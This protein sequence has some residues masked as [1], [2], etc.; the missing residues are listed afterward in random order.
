MSVENKITINNLV[1][2]LLFLVFGI[3]LLTSTDDLIGLVSKFIG[4]VLIITGIVKSIV[5]IYMKGKIGDYKL[6]ELI[7][8][9]LIIFCGVLLILYSS[10]LSFAIRI[11]FGIWTLLA[12]I[13]RMILSISV[14]NIDKT[15][16]KTYLVTSIIMIVIGLL[17]ISGLFDRLIGLFII[18]YS[19]LEIIDYVY[20]KSKCRNYESMDVI[21]K[22]KKSRKIK[23]KKV[24][25]AVI[26]EE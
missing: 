12:G 14:K 26:D 17:L 10:A 4:I 3:V 1:Y 15:G 25:D 6:S 2:A 22:D 23:G 21:K 24:I 7:I 13:N 18:S 5:Y 20:Y 16:F 19:I 11:I 8:G 9:L